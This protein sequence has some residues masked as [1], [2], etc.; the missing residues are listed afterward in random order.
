MT[1]LDMA[2][3]AGQPVGVRRR[4]ADLDAR[5]PRSSSRQ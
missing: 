4:R 2:G 3:K 5:S 1:L